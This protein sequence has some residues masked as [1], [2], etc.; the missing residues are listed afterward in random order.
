M[1]LE[2][3]K[4]RINYL[5]GDQ[6]SRI[7][8]QKL[9]SF[10]WA[11]KNDYNS[12]TLKTENGELW[13]CLINENNLKSDY[14]KK[15]VSVE[16][17]S[18]LEAGDTFEM[19]DD[20]THWMVYLPELTE[21]AY[22]RSEIIRCRYQLTVDG[23][24]YWVYFQG[25]TETDL[26]W[27]IKSQINVNELNLSG[28]IYIKSN[29]STKKHFKRFTKI[30]MDGHTWEVQVTDS[31]T[32]PGIIELEVQEYYDNTIEE[33]PHVTK[34]ESSTS[35]IIG[36]ATV[37]P[38]SVVGYSLPEGATNEYSVWGIEGNDN[39]GILE[40]FDD[41]RV[42]SVKV[43]EAAAGSFTLFYGDIQL[44]VDIDSEVP[45]ISGPQEVYPYDVCE[46]TATS[47]GDSV[48]FVVSDTSIAKITNV[49]GNVCRLEIITGKKGSFEIAATD[50]ETIQ[51]LVVKIKSF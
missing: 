7:N 24:D 32:V 28:T 4:T 21:T 20:G 12:R 47:L 13:Q 31:I 15:Y 37:K 8:K 14:D 49:E 46:Y 2:T 19:M 6:L 45:A 34:D 42:C 17:D 50:G 3:M 10:R 5:G 1:S 11:L 38:N 43:G 41:D 40:T 29:E 22:L 26:R 36:Q 27:F 16:F 48:K 23:V 9:Q 51:T 35:E 33:M 44:Q 30:K 18:H 39:V 25:P